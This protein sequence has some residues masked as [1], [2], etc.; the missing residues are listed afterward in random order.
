[1]GRQR[2]GEVM[3]VVR[4]GAFL[5]ATRTWY[6]CRPIPMA[7]PTRKVSRDAASWLQSQE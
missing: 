5:L 7:P 4:Q 1:V 3:G 6:E 2:V